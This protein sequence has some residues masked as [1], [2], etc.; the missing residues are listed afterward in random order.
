ML[1]EE[2][3]G[4]NITRNE[5]LY[6]IRQ[7]NNDLNKLVSGEYLRNI[8]AY[9][10]NSQTPPKHSMSADSRTKL[11]NVI[12]REAKALHTTVQE[13]FIGPTDQQCTCEVI[14]SI[15]YLWFYILIYQYSISLC[16][17]CHIAQ[18]YD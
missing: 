17:R 14:K 8:L 2:I 13:G 7:R 1:I 12:Q 16:I 10:R 6:R 4:G 9:S 11:F 3:K 5:Q 15:Y 18:L